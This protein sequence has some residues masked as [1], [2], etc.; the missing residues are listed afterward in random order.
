MSKS[1]T[2]SFLLCLIIN[3]PA[4]IKYQSEMPINALLNNSISRLVMVD[5]VTYS[6]VVAET[7]GLALNPTVHLWAAH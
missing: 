1:A 5:V 4:N 7:E 3:T 6:G 2:H